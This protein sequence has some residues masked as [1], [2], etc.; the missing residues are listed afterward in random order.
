MDAPDHDPRNHAGPFGFTLREAIALTAV[1]AVSVVVIGYSEWRDRNNQTPGWVIE[2]V[3]INDDNAADV[4]DTATSR[5]RDSVTSPAPQRL[6]QAQSE[7][8]NVNTGDQR[9]LARLPGIG[10]ELARRMIQERENN[11]PFVN[12]TDLQRVRGIGPRKAAMLSGWVTFDTL[13]HVPEDD[14]DQ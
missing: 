11:G 6:Q 1:M 3:L 9:A 5:P 8:I 4:G 10:P 7:L 13:K 2:D 12:L 14:G